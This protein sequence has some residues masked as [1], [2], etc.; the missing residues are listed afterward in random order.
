MKVFC[1]KDDIGCFYSFKK[2]KYYYYEKGLLS[3]IDDDGGTYFYTPE[4]FKNYFYS[5]SELRKIK[6]KKIYESC[7]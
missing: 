3:L 4:R 7:L 6:L 1:K 2:G 5:L